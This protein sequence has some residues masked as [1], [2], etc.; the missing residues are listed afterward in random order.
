MQH[1]IGEHNAAAQPIEQRDVEFALQQFDAPADR[2]LR[3][4][5]RRRRAAEAAAAGNRHE[6]PDLIHVH[7]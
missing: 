3:A 5:Q 1:G 2:R 7:E 6:S 4:V